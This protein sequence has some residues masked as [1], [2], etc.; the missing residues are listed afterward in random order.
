LYVASNR[1]N[2]KAPPRA[3]KS[4]KD[5]IAAYRRGEIEVDTPVHIVEND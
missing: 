1:V 3:F 2:K 4:A 5:A